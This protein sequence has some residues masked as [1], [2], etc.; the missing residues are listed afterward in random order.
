MVLSSDSLTKENFAAYIDH[1]LL[2]P[3]AQLSDIK[4]LCQEAIQHQ[5][6][7]ICINPYFVPY[8]K[9]FLSATKVDLCTVIGFPLGANT[10][11]I[12]AR[13]TQQAYS[14]G[15]TEID[16]VLNIGKLKEGDLEE[17][18]Y[19]IQSVSVV[20]KE[21]GLV[22]KIIIETCLLTDDEIK[23][24]C[25]LCIQA[26]VN[27]VKTSTGLQQAGATLPQVTLIS[28]C[29][30][31]TTLKVKASGGIKSYAFARALIQAGADRLG[32]SKAVE[33]MGSAY[34]D[35]L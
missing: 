25:E 8:A 14:D 6:K 10:S 1:T 28:S 23:K 7:A 18:S 21:L 2:K 12:K 32:L 24:A 34:G 30:Q 13:E 17:A 11:S 35:S 9:E 5:F 29:L 3:D 31:Q 22:S 33:I 15:A 19:D 4:K 27:F 20:C 16:M 26:D